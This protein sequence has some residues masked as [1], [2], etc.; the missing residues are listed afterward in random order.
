MNEEKICNRI[1]DIPF[2]R[3]YDIE[4]LIQNQFNSGSNVCILIHSNFFNDQNN[5]VEDSVIEKLYNE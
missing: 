3:I 5:Q 4:K 2:D 1:S